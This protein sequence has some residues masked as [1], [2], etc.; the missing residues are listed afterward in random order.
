MGHNIMKEHLLMSATKC[1]SWTNFV[2]DIESIEHA[3]KT[4]TAPT[5]M[6]LDPFQGNCNISGKYGHT[7]K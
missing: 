2:R 3:R 7:A 6:E 1:E 5:Q 4:I